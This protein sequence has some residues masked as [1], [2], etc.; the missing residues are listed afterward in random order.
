MSETALESQLDKLRDLFQR[1]LRI[2]GRT[3]DALEPTSTLVSLQSSSNL[4][5]AQRLPTELVLAI[6]EFLIPKPFYADA[7][8]FNVGDPAKL[9]YEVD[10]TH[11][12]Q[13]P[14][15]DLAR[16]CRVCKGWRAILS[17]LL[18]TRVYL[19][20]PERI[21][22]FGRTVKDC[23][24]APLVKEIYIF[25]QDKTPEEDASRITSFLT[26]KR[27][28]IKDVRMARTEL[29]NILRYCAFTRSISISS[30]TAAEAQAFT[31]D[32]DFAQQTN[33][34]LNYI[35]RLSIWGALSTN[36]TSMSPIIGPDVHLHQLQVL[37]LREVDFPTHFA[38][39]SLPR[40][41]TLQIARSFAWGHRNDDAVPISLRRMPQLRSLELYQN[42]F[43]MLVQSDCLRRLERLHLFGRKESVIM[44]LWGAPEEIT[45]DEPIVD[46]L[47]HLAFDSFSPPIPDHHER[48]GSSFQR[49]LR[50][51]T[52]ESITVL[53][54]P[55]T[56]RIHD[57]SAPP[58]PAVSSI[59][60]TML[61]I[62]L[63]HLKNPPK[64]LKMKELTLI[65]PRRP[66]SAAATSTEVALEVENRLQVSVR[67]NRLDTIKQE[68]KQICEISG[69]VFRV[70]ENEE[71]G[72]W[73]TERL[74][75][76]R[77]SF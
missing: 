58:P 44:S 23:D 49:L 13:K 22:L 48:L 67:E 74:M 41:H 9:D 6:F 42:N 20:C 25:S 4:S 33:I 31:I 37:C 27:G 38:F 68:I 54:R 56:Y 34:T 18:Y 17:E 69:I 15:A 21:R 39:P 55:G 60:V 75:S 7:F 62:L 12:V 45:H 43:H 14:Q 8:S 66:V 40:L 72:P 71:F 32:T 35:R 63:E 53:L 2:R 19:V 73:V 64:P 50:P 28:D 70:L 65:K 16:F 24:V 1:A 29:V 61:N 3:D 76:D 46:N 51:C 47:R 11:S 10:T 77:L 57:P 26:G 5:L 52:L 30:R 36:V 59:D